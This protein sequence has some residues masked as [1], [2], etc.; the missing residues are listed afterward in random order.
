LG[1][2]WLLVLTIVGTT[3]GNIN[4]QNDVRWP[5]DPTY[6]TEQL[7]NEAGKTLADKLQTEVGTANGVVFWKCQEASLDNMIK[8]AGKSAPKANGQ[9]L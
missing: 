7:C 2:I 4:V 9:P 3:D 1:S 8:G 5:N 6:N